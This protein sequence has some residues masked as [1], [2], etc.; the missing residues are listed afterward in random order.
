MNALTVVMLAFSVLGAVDRIIG[1]KFGLGKQFERGFMLFGNMAL[2]MIGM[3]IIS[4]FLADI[5]SPVFSGFYK[6][7]SIDPSIIPASLFAN[8]MGGA[9]LA[10][11]IA[12]NENIGMFNALVVSSMMGATIS[13]TIP[14]ALA[15][16][17][18]DKHKDVM[19]G[20]LCGIAT[21]PLGCIFSG[22][23]C[24]INFFSLIYNLIPLILFS[25]IIILGLTFCPKVA[26]K[27]FEIIGLFI[28]IIITIGLALGIIRFLTG[29]E[30]IKGLDTL[31]NGAAICL[32]ASVVMT[33]AFPMIHCISM[34]LNRPIKFMGKKLSINETSALGFISTLATNVTTFE[35]MNSMDKKGTVLNSAFAVSAAFTFAGHL[36]FTMAF[37]A[38]YLLP[39]I[40]G[41]LISGIAGLIVAVFI[42]NKTSNE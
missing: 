7:F 2:S 39:M 29:Y 35:M 23:I 11:E 10:K 38:H 6:L 37:D 13:F 19:L 5:L 16:V 9:S 42:F 32:N 40:I 22:V 4:P 25:V 17:S 24:K 41:K 8:D 20:L 1:N 12:L 30:I 31:E 14:Y 26:I 18:P 28:K 21:V 34:L 15:A 27:V 33:G 3:I 36:A